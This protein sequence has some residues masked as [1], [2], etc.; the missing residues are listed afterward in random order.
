MHAV[1]A[2]QLRVKILFPANLLRVEEHCG[3]LRAGR[4]VAK[5]FNDNHDRRFLI[6]LAFFQTLLLIRNVCI[7]NILCC[8]IRRADW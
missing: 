7:P 2:V 6:D 8:H 4:N 3:T 1:L 5:V